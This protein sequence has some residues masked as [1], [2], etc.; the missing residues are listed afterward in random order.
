MPISSRFR[1]TGPVPSGVMRGVI[2]SLLVTCAVCACSEAREAPRVEL[3]VVA[4]SSGLV[5]VRTNLGYDV[6]L[7]EVRL[8]VSDI[9]FSGG[10]EAAAFEPL[11]RALD[12]LVPS[13]HAHPGHGQEGD[14]IGELRGRFIV[15]YRPGVGGVAQV[16]VASLIAD[17]YASGNF[18]L[19][20]ASV[21]DDLPSGDR[22]IGH[23]AVLA[24]EASMDGWSQRFE[25]LLDSSSA[26]VGAPFVE[27]VEPS[28]RGPLQLRLLSMD[29]EGDS[30]FDDV[31]FAAVEA[32]GGDVLII[33]ATSTD[34][35]GRA[36]Y[37][38]LLGTLESHDHFEWRLGSSE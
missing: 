1:S 12:V 34:R 28:T 21:E 4:E 23:A 35:G 16:G 36:A 5:P 32:P 22:L 7:E 27:R 9:E 10:G 33:D 11:L 2:A 31:D 30:L 15:P 20:R 6:T 18:K 29:S 38:T 25:A 37:A 26:L 8:A 19:S 3:A 13:A 17:S 14:V 24:G